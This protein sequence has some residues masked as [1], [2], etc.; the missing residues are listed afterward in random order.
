M[1]RSAERCRPSSSSTTPKIGP[2]Y[3][4]GPIAE[5]QAAARGGYQACNRRTIH[6]LR[7]IGVTVETLPYPQ[8]EGKG[9]DKLLAYLTGFVRLLV[10]VTGLPQAA[11][12]HIT[13]LYKQFIYIEWIIVQ[14]ARLRRCRVMYDIRAGSMLRHFT[15]RTSIYRATFA[16]VLRSADVV[17]IEGELY[18]P[19]V[20]RITGRPALYLPNHV[21]SSFSPNLERVAPIGANVKLAYVGRVAPE[22]GIEVAL[23]TVQALRRA[24]VL[25]TAT[26]MGSGEP[27]YIGRMRKRFGECHVEWTG[28]LD[29]AGVLARLATAHFFIFPTAH[30]GEGHSNALTEAMLAGCVPIVSDCGFNRQVVGPSGLVLP[31]GATSDDY[32]DTVKKVIESAT[33]LVLS[34][35]TS[36]RC[37]ELFSSARV[38]Q[39]LVG[40][41]R[42]LQ[43][44]R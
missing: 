15:T 1:F 24:D 30:S 42:S 38:V 5:A 2:V 13:G 44:T 27:R 17:A 3:L 31:V 16:S 8:P 43:A 4:C 14:I 6:A 12:V 28:A 9:L 37:R 35:R 18:R 25:A 23:E 10:R 19:L 7:E 21:D 20:E 39:V 26:V 40:S 34:T 41:Y 33:W 22:K 32:A 29:Q 11:I 36:A